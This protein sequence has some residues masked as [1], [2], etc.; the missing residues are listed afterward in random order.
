MKSLLISK[1]KSHPYWYSFIALITILSIYAVFFHNPK[2]IMPDSFS[3]DFHVENIDKLREYNN[4]VI[5]SRKAQIN[6]K[7][8][9]M[10]TTTAFYVSGISVL[11]LSLMRIDVCN[12]F[13]LLIN[14][15]FKLLTGTSIIIL[16]LFIAF[17]HKHMGSYTHLIATESALHQLN[18]KLMG[19]DS[20]MHDELKYNPNVAIAY[21]EK[22]AIR[23]DKFEKIQRQYCIG[24]KPF[25]PFIWFIHKFIYNRFDNKISTIEVQEA[26]MYDIMIFF[27]LIFLYTVRKML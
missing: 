10:W 14:G 25:V 18:L 19:P 7:E 22:T 26:V 21:P 23:I 3:S 12:K 20:T 6:R 13:K 27:T 5:S 24:L 8:V 11:L 2:I 15:K 16:L 4:E 9:A 17:V 1:F